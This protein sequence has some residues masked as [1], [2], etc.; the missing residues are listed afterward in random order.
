MKS[1]FGSIIT[2]YGQNKNYTK[3]DWHK[4]KELFTKFTYIIFN[5]Y[6]LYLPILYLKT[7]PTLC[8]ALGVKKDYSGFMCEKS[9]RQTL[10]M[11]FFQFS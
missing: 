9:D 8:T 3:T 1:T 11:V 4:L 5:I 10:H 2:N 6:I 7:L